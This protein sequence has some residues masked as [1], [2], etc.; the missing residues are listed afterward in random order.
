M[1][2]KLSHKQRFVSRRDQVMCLLTPVSVR[3][4]SESLPKNDRLFSEKA[5]TPT[6][7]SF[8]PKVLRRLTDWTF[9]SAPTRGETELL[10]EKTHTISG[11]NKNDRVPRKA[12]TFNCGDAK[13]AHS[14]GIP[15][16][17]CREERQ[18]TRR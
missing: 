5:P 9:Y 13:K 16:H 10:T 2:S 7:E 11:V 1:S 17:A 14:P 15:N 3:N 6:Y 18:I 4:Q 12:K 8:R